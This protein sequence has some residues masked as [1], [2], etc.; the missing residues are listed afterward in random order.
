LIFRPPGK[1][2][3]LKTTTIGGLGVAA[4][5]GFDRLLRQ[6]EE[7]IIALSVFLMAL[8]LIANVILRFFNRSFHPTEELSQ[9]L[10]FFVTFIGTSY[11][12][13]TGLHIR[14]SLLNDVLS[15]AP[16]KALALFVSLTT[17]L[18]LFYV[19]YLSWR[20][21]ARVG[22]QNRV[23][24]IL[25]WPVYYVYLVMPLGFLLTGLQYVLTFIRNIISPGAWISYAVQ[26]ENTL[27]LGAAADE[28]PAAGK[29]G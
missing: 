8:I 28:K 18:I 24:P 6:L 12:A 20:Y 16:R 9:F 14:M 27:G 2:E 21:V 11:A 13:R 5:R 26:H 1:G 22:A 7:K 3:G 4:L 17:A 29:E 25:Q 23:S 10:I 19:A 15:G